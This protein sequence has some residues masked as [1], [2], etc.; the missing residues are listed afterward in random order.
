MTAPQ[1]KFRILK[2][3]TKNIKKSAQIWSLERVL[4]F[5]YRFCI[6]FYFSENELAARQ[7]KHGDQRALL[8]QEYLQ[9]LQVAHH[10]QV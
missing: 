10:Q 5:L 3:T 2:T 1:I 6:D 9:A 4:K 7:R 8:H